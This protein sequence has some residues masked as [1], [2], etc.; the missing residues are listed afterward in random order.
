MTSQLSFVE[1]PGHFLCFCLGLMSILKNTLL[2]AAF[3]L[4]L[5]ISSTADSVLSGAQRGAVLQS[6]A[7][8]AEMIAQQSERFIQVSLDRRLDGSPRAVELTFYDG[9]QRPLATIELKAFGLNGL[10]IY[11]GLVPPELSRAWGKLLDSQLILGMQLRVPLR[12]GIAEVFGTA[13]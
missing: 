12:R 11:Q 2:I 8:V 3:A 9:H 10:T 7:R 5:F 4:F 1:N 13:P 6:P